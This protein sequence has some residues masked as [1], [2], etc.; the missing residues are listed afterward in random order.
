MALKSIFLAL[1]EKDIS[2]HF[3]KRLAHIDNNGCPSPSILNDPRHAYVVEVHH[4]TD[5]VYQ[6]ITTT[7]SIVKQIE[8]TPPDQWL[9]SVGLSRY[10][11]IQQCLDHYSLVLFSALDRALLLANLLMDIQ[12]P[13]K[14]VTF[15]KIIKPIRQRCSNTATMLGDLYEKTGKLA[16]HRNFY[17]HRGESRNAGRL[18]SIH[19]VKV[20]TQLFNVPTDTVKFHDAEADSELRDILQMEIDEIELAVVS[21]L[22]VISSFYVAGIDKLGGL[23]I[24]DESEIQRAQQAIRYFEGGERPSFMDNS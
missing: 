17:S 21:F 6:S 10:R 14:E 7:K 1:I 11:F 19:R 18:S 13:E 20:I 9:E 4:K 24:P 2:I 12:L 16:D 5:N 23:D 15:K 3:M 22:D 8:Q